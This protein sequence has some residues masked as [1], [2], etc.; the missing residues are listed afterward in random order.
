MHWTYTPQY[1]EAANIETIRVIGGRVVALR[2]DCVHATVDIKC[3][4][5]RK[6]AFV[7]LQY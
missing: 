1:K 5:E 7:L 3:K 4:G 2:L 6:I